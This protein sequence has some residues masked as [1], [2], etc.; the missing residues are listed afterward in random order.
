[1]TGHGEAGPEAVTLAARIVSRGAGQR[2]RP[3]PGAPRV[4]IRYAATDERLDLTVADDGRGFDPATRRGR[5]GRPPRADRDARARTRLR[6]RL[7]D[8]VHP[9][10]RDARHAMDSALDTSRPTGGA[11]PHVAM[12][13]VA[14][15]GGRADARV[16]LRARRQAQR[17]AVSPLARRAAP[18]PTA[19]RSPR[20]GSTS[21][22]SRPRA[23]W[24]SPRSSSSISVEDY[25][26]AWEPE[27]EAALAR[28]FDAAWWARFP[29]GPDADDHRA[30]GRLRR[31]LGRALPRPPVRL[32]VPVH[33][34]RRRAR[35]PRGA[36]AATHDT[37]LT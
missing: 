23:G 2:R 4:E 16:L 13:L 26:H 15:G 34:R 20:P 17:L 25:V 5:R 18:T 11:C 37:V 27:M 29:I 7:R 33:R 31:R 21:S 10:R 8:H 12:L 24:C 32:A 19:P 36:T 22:G 14:A 6:R 9:G 28:G 1:M 3:R 30:L 35:P